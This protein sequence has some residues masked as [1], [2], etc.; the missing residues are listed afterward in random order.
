MYVLTIG[1]FWRE[2]AVRRNV[3]SWGAGSTDFP[4]AHP[5]F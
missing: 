2:A 5:D 3:R 4:V 1:R